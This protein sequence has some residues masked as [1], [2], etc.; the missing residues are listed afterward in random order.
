MLDLCVYN[1]RHFL[2][3]KRVNTYLEDHMK[4][5]DRLVVRLIFWFLLLC[6]G[7]IWLSML[8]CEVNP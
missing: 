8:I 2:G 5:M 6:T 7:I 1:H 3:R 4:L